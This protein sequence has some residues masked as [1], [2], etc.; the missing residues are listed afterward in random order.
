MSRLDIPSP[1]S[2]AICR[3]R[4]TGRALAADEPSDLGGQLTR[5][6]SD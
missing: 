1:T 6:A 4:P 3:S 2:A 5:I